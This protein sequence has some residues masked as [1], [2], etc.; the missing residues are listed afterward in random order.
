MGKTLFYFPTEAEASVF[1]TLRPDADVRIIGVGMVA[2]GTFATA[3][4]AGLAPTRIVLCGIAGACDNRLEVGQVVEVVRDAEAG[5]P[6]AYAKTYEMTPVTG[7]KC[8]ES[9]TVSHSGDSLR[10]LTQESDLPCIEQME[11]AAV[12]AA[13][14]TIDPVEFYHLRAISN[15]VGDRRSEWRVEEAVTALGAVVAQI[16]KD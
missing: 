8:V 11:G 10:F 1:K 14:Q 15:R 5:L 16:F 3:L 7:L 6:E 4:I 2:S 9:L 12:A 13:C